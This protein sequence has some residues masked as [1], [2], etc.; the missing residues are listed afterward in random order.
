ML[1]GLLKHRALHMRGQQAVLPPQVLCQAL[2]AAYPGPQAVQGQVQV[3]YHQAGNV[4]IG[5]GRV[6][7]LQVVSTPLH[8]PCSGSL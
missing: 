2:Q 8:E 4:D 3:G 1:L 7:H 5:I 6:L